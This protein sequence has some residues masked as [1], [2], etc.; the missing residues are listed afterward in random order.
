M[1]VPK[2]KRNVSEVAFFDQ[3]YKVEETVIKY[4]MSDFGTVM[5]YR[6]LTVFTQKAKMDAGDKEIFNDLIEKYHIN[7][8]A[9]YPQYIFDYYR[10]CILK[11]CSELVSLISKAYTMYPNSAFEFNTKRQY[12]TDA[13]SVCYDMK[14]TLQIAIKIFNSNHL[15][16]FVP[17]INDI[18]KEIELLKTWRKDSNKFKKQC[19]ENDERYRAA[20]SVRV[21]KQKEKQKMSDNAFL[22]RI[23]NV[24]NMNRGYL[25]NNMKIAQVS[26]DEFGRPK[27]DRIVPAIYYINKD[28]K[29]GNIGIDGV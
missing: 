4:V 11:Q 12:Q 10:E 22:A 28:G 6:D 16:K 21:E 29:I 23:L 17:I 8:E 19:Y 5:R 14:H 3:A 18:D 1:S 13:I 27:S 15:E 25:I 20:A 2:G 26:I 24:A 7:V 9:S